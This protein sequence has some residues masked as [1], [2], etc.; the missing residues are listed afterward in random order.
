[1]TSARG[2]FARLESSGALTAGEDE[3]AAAAAATRSLRPHILLA[4]AL[5]CQRRIDK[6]E[7]HCLVSTRDFEMENAVLTLGHF[8]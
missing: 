4:A 2:L 8:A 6:I 3:A 5:E 7:V 1:M